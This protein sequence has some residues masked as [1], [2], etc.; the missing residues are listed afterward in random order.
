MVRIG[1]AI[2]LLQRLLPDSRIVIGVDHK[3]DDDWCKY[4][5]QYHFEL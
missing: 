4:F 5:Y 2:D 3:M 1:F